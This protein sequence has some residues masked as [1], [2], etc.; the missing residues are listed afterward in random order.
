M[1][2][3]QAVNSPRI[4]HQW[5]PEVLM[6]EDGYGADTESLLTNKGYRLYSSRT[7]GSVQAIVREGDYFYGAADPRRPS[8][9]AVAP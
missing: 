5:L 1:N 8:S 7:M 6:I 2:I 3:A 4:H 9:G